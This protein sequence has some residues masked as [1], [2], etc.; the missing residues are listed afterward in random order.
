MTRLCSGLFPEQSYQILVANL[1]LRT[2][3]A[4]SSPSTEGRSCWATQTPT[5]E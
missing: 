2:K 1:V 3:Q 4:V 5:M